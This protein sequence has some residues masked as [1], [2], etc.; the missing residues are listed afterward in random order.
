MH[1]HKKLQVTAKR[2]F[3]ALTLN[4]NDPLR[5]NEVCLILNVQVLLMMPPLHEQRERIRENQLELEEGR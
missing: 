3:L 4:N 1:T 5:S 2:Y